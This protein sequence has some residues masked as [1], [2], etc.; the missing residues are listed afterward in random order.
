MAIFRPTG[1]I[2][3]TCGL[4]HHERS[5]EI[6]MQL[7]NGAFS[8][9]VLKNKP[10]L[11]SQ[12]AHTSAEIPATSDVTFEAHKE[13]GPHKNPIGDD[14]ILRV[15]LVTLLHFHNVPFHSL[16]NPFL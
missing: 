4:C 14:T 15:Y 11:A 12:F 10:G 3:L 7:V 5:D 16:A 1:R 9:A 8:S 2:P 6:A 13:R